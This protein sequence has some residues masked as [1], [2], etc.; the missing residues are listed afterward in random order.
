M[1]I[2]NSRAARR[3][4]PAWSS[5]YAFS[6]ASR[7]AVLLIS[8]IIEKVPNEI[9]RLEHAKY[10]RVLKRQFVSVFV[11]QVSNP[12]SIVMLPHRAPVCTGLLSPA[13]AMPPIRAPMMHQRIQF[14]LVQRSM[15]QNR[16]PQGIS[17][18]RYRAQLQ[19]TAATRRGFGQQ[20]EWMMR[21]RRAH[22]GKKRTGPRQFFHQEL[23]P[24]KNR[25][26]PAR[27]P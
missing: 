12:T 19:H 13:Y 23:H 26:G 20:S 3:S 18:R 10:R 5:L 1:N 27:C 6:N 15:R 21:R 4:S 16:F 2:I 8:F 24:L 22:V 25:S 11:A 7:A 9:I 14:H 17:L